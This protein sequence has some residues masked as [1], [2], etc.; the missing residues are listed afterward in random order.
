MK[1]IRHGVGEMD[2]FVLWNRGSDFR[3]LELVVFGCKITVIVL[4]EAHKR[5]PQPCQTWRRG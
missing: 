2:G 3:Y 5:G 4:A 1:G